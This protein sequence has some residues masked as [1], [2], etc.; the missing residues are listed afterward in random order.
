[1]LTFFAISELRVGERDVVGVEQAISGGLLPF[2]LVVEVAT[3][4]SSL[5][6]CFFLAARKSECE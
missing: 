5:V 4:E 1:M 6:S 3:R 2:T